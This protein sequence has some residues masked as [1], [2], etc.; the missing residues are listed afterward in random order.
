MRSR[1]INNRE[2][3]TKGKRRREGKKMG[4]DEKEAKCL[5]RISLGECVHIKYFS[6][7]IE[8]FCSAVSAN[9]FACVHN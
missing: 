9:G 1:M 4:K 3:G 8:H 5:F 2:I 6:Y 7:F